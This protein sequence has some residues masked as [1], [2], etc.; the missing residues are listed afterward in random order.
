MEGS[1]YKYQ[2]LCEWILQ[3]IREGN[4]KHRSRIPSEH[5]LC[6]K[7]QVSRQTVR[8]A[9]RDLI[10]RGFLRS[11]QGKGTFVINR[12]TQ[13]SKTIGVLVSFT[14]DF[15]FTDVLRGI[16]EVMGEAGYGI[17]LGITDNRIEKE[18][19]FLLRMLES[20][21]AGLIIEGTR[22]TFPNPNVVL[23]NK[24]RAKGVQIVF[25]HNSY[26]DFPCDSIVM[27][28][29]ESSRTMV[30]KLIE[31]GHTRIAGIFKGDDIQ[32]IRRYEGYVSALYENGIPIDENLIGWFYENY[33]EN[34]HLKT[35]ISNILHLIEDYTA[36]VCYNDFIAQIVYN[37]FGEEGKR[38]PEDISVVSFDDT[39]G[40]YL[41]CGLTTAAHPKI[42]IGTEA[43]LCLLRRIEEDIPDDVV[44]EKFLKTDIVY[45]ESIKKV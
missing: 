10:D 26:A 23:L 29:A 3:N 27:E 40:G 19:A 18:E 12:K 17:E 39:I 41:G 11:E 24:L 42:R 13:H 30:N 7:F 6:Q 33:Y 20:D 44:H 22:T 15:L 8:R 21:I 4:F 36:L 25:I 32:G 9:I 1:S 5:F 37:L 31:M 16:E 45:R 2:E 28:D 43:A 14:Y 38:I 35:I 34:V